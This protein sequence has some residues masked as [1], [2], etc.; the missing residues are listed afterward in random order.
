MQ[1]LLIRDPKE[2][3]AIGPGSLSVF[4]GEL[5]C[6]HLLSR[7]RGSNPRKQ[8]V[9]Y[10]VGKFSGSNVCGVLFFVLRHNG[11]SSV[12]LTSQKLTL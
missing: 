11:K 9:F 6:S 7:G 2:L 4:R 10:S 1:I 12:F 5:C 3:V 8:T